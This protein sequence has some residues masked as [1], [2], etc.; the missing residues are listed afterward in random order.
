MKRKYLIPSFCFFLLISV[1][2]FGNTD[3]NLSAT[4]IDTVKLPPVQT[5]LLQNGT[6]VFYIKD[7]L[8]VVTIYASIGYGSLHEGRKTAGL[9]TLAAKTIS[10]GRSK[11]YPGAKLHSKIDRI[12]GDLSVSSSYEGFYISIRV[13]K[14]FKNE[15]FKILNDIIQNPNIE[16]QYLN[17]AR[18][19][20]ID[21]IKRRYDKPIWVARDK[22]M[23]LIFD[24]QGYGAIPTVENMKSF[25]TNDI[26][27]IWEKHL[28]SKNIV[29]GVASSIEFSQIKKDVEKYFKAIPEGERI[30]YS[31]QYQKII[32]NL[33][34]KRGKIF[35]YPKNIP[36]AVVF[37]GTV[38]PDINYKGTYALNILNFIL[39][40]SSFNSRLMRE[41]RVKRGM[42]Y[43]A[44]SS[45]VFRYKTGVFLAYSQTKNENIGTVVSLMK[46]NI[47]GMAQK[48]ISEEE[49]IW[50]K[51][52]IS[53]SYIFNFDTPMKNLGNY[54]S[55]EYY[56]LP[57]DYYRRYLANINSVTAHKIVEEGQ[58]LFGKGLVTCIVGKKELLPRLKQFGEV[59]VLGKK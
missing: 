14:Q 55:L 22:G 6:K 42:A 35:L 48:N 34:Q 58:E 13:L 21:N 46:E 31:L 59:I 25:T 28:K 12:G 4:G 38:A 36:Q 18:S 5:F 19:L 52:A 49:L 40:G 39:G 1:F 24:G 2:L 16:P 53:N 11:N 32:E 50:A 23:D 47:N 41:I 26:R 15:A 57:D 56:K 8:P 27:Q 30:D 3:H 37:V 9:S 17:R 29:I 20:L 33:N 45:L 10:L 43:S 51:K 7:E 54:I 44:G